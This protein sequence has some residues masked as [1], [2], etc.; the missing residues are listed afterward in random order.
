MYCVEKALVCEFCSSHSSVAD[1]LVIF[2]IRETLSNRKMKILRF[3]HN[4][5][6]RLTSDVTL[7]RRTLILKLFFF[8]RGGTRK[9]LFI[10]REI[11]A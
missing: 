8:F 2:R 3:F 6:K 9:I 10:S 1:D 5:G 4:V 7:Y 11:P